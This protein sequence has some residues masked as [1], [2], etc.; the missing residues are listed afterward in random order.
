VSEQP[1]RA[2]TAWKVRGERDVGR[3]G[4]GRLS[5]ASVELPDGVTFDQYVLRLP[6]AAIVAALDE[7]ER[8]L[9]LWRHRFIIDRW[10]WEL[11][12][13]HLDD[14]EDAATAAAREFE[15]ET[16][17]RPRS[18][19]F[20]LRFQ[21]MVG[22]AD[23]ENH[24]FLARGADHLGDPADINEAE[25]VRWIPLADALAMIGTGEIAGAASVVG[26]LQV[27]AMRQA[28]RSDPG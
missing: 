22:A 19:E 10:V 20:L 28:E 26:I 11:P 9:M 6:P 1:A 16:G 18:V 3:A 25:E 14:G 21:P 12:G 4:R 7:H 2:P 15:E 24:V 8:L 17:W 27:A 13:G 23:C 5:T